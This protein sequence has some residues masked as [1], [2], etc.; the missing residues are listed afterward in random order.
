VQFLSGI[1]AGL[2]RW[3]VL[4]L[5][6]LATAVLSPGIFYLRDVQRKLTFGS[7]PSSFGQNDRPWT[8]RPVYVSRLAAK[9]MH[10]DL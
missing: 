9:L 3:T 6:A 1:L 4:S 8:Q 2:G 5:N 10:V 7:K